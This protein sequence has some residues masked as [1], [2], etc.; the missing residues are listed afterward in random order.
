MSD[1]VASHALDH[2]FTATLEK[3]D[4]PGGWVY[5]RTDWSA[6]FF[7]TRG[8]VKVRARSTAIRSRALSWRSATGRTSC[9]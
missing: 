8:P 3:S 9:P 6:E 2:T 1:P 5:L 4:A 7:A